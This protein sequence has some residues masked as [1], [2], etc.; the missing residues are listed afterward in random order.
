MGVS[1]TPTAFSS[2][3]CGIEEPLVD[4][5]GV[6]K[7]KGEKKGKWVEARSFRERSPVRGF[8]YG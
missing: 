8:T 6:G 4:F 2:V 5:G 1:P 7:E 3:C